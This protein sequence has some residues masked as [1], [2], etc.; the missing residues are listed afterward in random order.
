MS[1]IKYPGLTAECCQLGQTHQ[2]HLCEG[3]QNDRL[4][5]QDLEDQ[6][7]KDQGSSMQGASEAHSGVC[8]HAWVE[9]SNQKDINKI[10]IQWRAAR[11]V[12]IRHQKTSNVDHML[13]PLHWQTFLRHR[14]Q[15]ASTCSSS[16]MQA[17]HALGAKILKPSRAG[18]RRHI[19][20]YQCLQR[21]TSHKN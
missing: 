3:Q 5:E 2:W 7:Q 14:Q 11:F 19:Q 13:M 8:L 4:P 18:Q 6:L 17:W 9:S 20:V 15:P 21:G 12:L 10:K 1:T 16:F